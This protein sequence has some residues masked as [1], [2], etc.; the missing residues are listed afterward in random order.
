[1]DGINGLNEYPVNLNLANRLSWYWTSKK[2]PNSKFSHKGSNSINPNTFARSVEKTNC[3][4][5]SIDIFSCESRRSSFITS[6]LSTTSFKEV[7][8]ILSFVYSPSCNNVFKIFRSSCEKYSF[9]EV[10][11][12]IDIISVWHMVCFSP[13]SL[14]FA[15]IESNHDCAFTVSS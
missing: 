7:I 10:L 5:E 4:W 14:I 3:G 12:L 2:F 13:N 9:H 1:M 15:R 8:I 6:T 11:F